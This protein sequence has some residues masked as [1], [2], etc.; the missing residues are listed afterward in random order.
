MNLEA[1]LRS[2][3]EPERETFVTLVFDQLKRG[4]ASFLE[5]RLPNKTEYEVLQP[6]G[7]HVPGL[8]EATNYIEAERAMF[9][10]SC[11]PKNREPWS[12][13]WRPDADAQL[14][15]LAEET[16]EYYIQTFLSR[17]LAKLSPV[18]DRRPGY[19]VVK[20][21]GHLASGAWLGVLLFALPDGTRFE[22]RLQVKINFT[23]YG[24][25][26]GQYPCTV[27][28]AFKSIEEVWKSVGYTPPPKP[29]GPPRK[30]WTKV[31]SGSVVEFNGRP[32]LIQ[33]PGQLKKL[34]IPAEAP[35]IARI[36][37]STH[38]G[39]IE[40]VDGR[41]DKVKWPDGRREA[42]MEIERHMSYDTARRHMR[43]AAFEHFFGQPI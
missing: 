25:P 37:A 32:V 20:G 26:Y 1:T 38:Y 22:V 17:A 11:S 3:I 42:F 15:K 7:G 34:G 14:K 10:K 21:R 6:H 43:E 2:L 27:H 30:R 9:R 39:H 36:E 41:T 31:V 28:G 8:R 19:T 40:Y 23:K 35:Q 16:A 29:E 13:E 33:T 24:K 4:I 12:V 5:R 18:T